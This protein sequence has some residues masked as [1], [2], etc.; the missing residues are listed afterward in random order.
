MKNKF[1][2][3]FGSIV[4]LIVSILLSVCGNLGFVDDSMGYV[5]IVMLIKLVERWI[6]DGNN[7]VLELEKLGYKID[8]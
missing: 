8:F 3:I 5:G 1:R 6:V 4:I 7:M 2:K